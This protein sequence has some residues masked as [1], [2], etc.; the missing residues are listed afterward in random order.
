[1][2]IIVGLSGV[3]FGNFITIKVK[4]IKKFEISLKLNSL[5]NFIQIQIKFIKK[6]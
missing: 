5:K 4:F 1:M 6:I 2:G 3:I